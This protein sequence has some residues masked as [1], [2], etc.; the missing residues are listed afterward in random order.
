MVFLED[1]ATADQAVEDEDMDLLGFEDNNVLPQKFIAI[2]AELQKIIEKKE[3][4]LIFT[5]WPGVFPL[6]TLA[7]YEHGIAVQTLQGNMDLV[8]RQRNLDEFKTNPKV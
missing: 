2:I 8:V 5:Q 1:V 4:T 6:L 7:L 3:K